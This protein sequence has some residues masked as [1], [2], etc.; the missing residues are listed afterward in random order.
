MAD[1]LSSSPV[2]TAIAKLDQGDPKRR[3]ADLR[4][5]EGKLR[6]EHQE[7]F[8]PFQLRYA[9]ETSSSFMEPPVE[10]SPVAVTIR[11]E[12]GEAQG[13]DEE[14]IATMRSLLRTSRE[15]T[16]ALKSN[17]IPRGHPW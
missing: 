16:Q 6:A 3:A 10:Q 14:D 11:S 8:R 7:K 15:L 5:W 9:D 17:V 2:G 4:R 12:L 1:V 13:S